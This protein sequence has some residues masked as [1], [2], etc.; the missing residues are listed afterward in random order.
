MI[1]YF[2]RKIRLRDFEVWDVR[3]GDQHYALAILDE[4]RP[5]T[6]DDFEIPDLIYEEDDQRANY[7]SATYYSDEA[8]KDE[9]KE[10]LREFAQMLTEHLALAHCEV[11]IKIYQENPEKAIEQMMLTKYG[12]KESDMPLD[13]LLHFNQE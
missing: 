6:F 11:I 12:F 7:V 13:K 5:A 9:H 2:E 8:V 3:I 4:F 10:I 1:D